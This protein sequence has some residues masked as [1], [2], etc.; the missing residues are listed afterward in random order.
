MYF[1]DIIVKLENW[2]EGVKSKMKS[3]L[4]NI[5]RDLDTIGAQKVQ[6]LFSI[7]NV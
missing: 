5:Q 1:D 7:F 6:I 4:P 3:N 2:M